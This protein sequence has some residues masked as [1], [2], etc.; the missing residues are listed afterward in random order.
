MACNLPFFFLSR[1][2]NNTF[3]HHVKM[4]GRYLESG[5]QELIWIGVR[6]KLN[7]VLGLPLAKLTTAAFAVF[8]ISVRPHPVRIP[9]K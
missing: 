6:C 3:C 9:G 4:S 2:H 1:Q 8:G 5:H 7:D